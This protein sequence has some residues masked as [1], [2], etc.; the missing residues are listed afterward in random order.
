MSQLTCESDRAFGPIRARILRVRSVAHV[1]RVPILSCSRFSTAA[2][3][4]SAVKDLPLLILVNGFP[5]QCSLAPE[6]R[7][8]LQV[9]GSMEKRPHI[10]PQERL[11]RCGR[12]LGIPRKRADMCVVV[13]VTSE[14][15][16][17][18]GHLTWRW[19]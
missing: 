6:G 7:E 16:Y 9:R 4:E 18:R 14:P 8:K 3:L 5:P 12:Y 2:E 1:S 15:Y 19:P 11:S 17:S 13:F 10:K